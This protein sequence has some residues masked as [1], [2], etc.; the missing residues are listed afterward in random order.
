MANNYTSNTNKKLLKSFAKS[1]E[2]STVLTNTVSKQLVNDFDASTGKAY[3]DVSMKRPPQY[4]PQRTSDG[5]VTGST[6]PG[7]TGKQ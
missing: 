6:N 4:V 3:G 5:D 2:S 7:R 1:F